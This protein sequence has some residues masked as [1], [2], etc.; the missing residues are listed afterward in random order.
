MK[1]LYLYTILSFFLFYWVSTTL[2]NMPENYFKIG[3]GEQYTFF[4]RLFYQRWSFFA[5]PPQFNDRLYYIIRDKKSH[6]QRT[7]EVIGQ[8]TQQKQLKAPFNQEENLLDYAVNNSVLGMKNIQQENI[9]LIRY[10]HP[11][12]SD[13]FISKATLAMTWQHNNTSEA[14]RTLKRYGALVALKNNLPPADQEFKMVLSQK[15]IPKFKDRNN[16]DVQTA[17]AVVF[18]SPFYSASLNN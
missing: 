3:F 7:F 5:P 14:I 12:S 1:K 18:E 8:I 15:Q 4:H 17:E 10:L 9:K 13:S 6:Q 11:D 2:F 16:K